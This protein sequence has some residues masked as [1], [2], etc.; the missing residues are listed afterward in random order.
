[1]EPVFSRFDSY[2]FEAD[3]R[4]VAG[5]KTVREGAELDL[6]LFFYNRSGPLLL[7]QLLS[8]DRSGNQ[9]HILQNKLLTPLTIYELKH[10]FYYYLECVNTAVRMALYDCVYS[11]VTP[12]NIYH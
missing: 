10:Y 6:K 7:L 12:L 9:S 5:V 8:S 1:M 11:C 3:E 2:K 4:F